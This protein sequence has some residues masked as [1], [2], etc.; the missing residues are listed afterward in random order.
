M[1]LTSVLLE[2]SW[3]GKERIVMNSCR[4]KNFS[5][6]WIDIRIHYAIEL[7]FCNYSLSSVIV[8][9][10][11]NILIMWRQSSRTTNR[12]YAS[13]QPTPWKSNRI[14]LWCTHWHPPWT[15]VLGQTPPN[16]SFH[17]ALSE[18]SKKAIFPLISQRKIYFVI[19]CSHSKQLMDNLLSLTRRDLLSVIT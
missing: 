6:N 15:L 18:F 11:S 19:Y 3:W 9:R 16:L 1:V 4:F 13:L 5:K 8:L 17:R 2:V 14:Q 7:V 12:H 10:S